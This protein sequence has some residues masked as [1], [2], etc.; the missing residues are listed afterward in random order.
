A[1]AG[2]GSARERLDQFFAL[3]MRPDTGLFGSGYAT[4]DVGSAGSMAIDGM[5]ITCWMSMGLIVGLVCIGALF[6]AIGN[7]IAGAWSCEGGNGETNVVIGA[8]ACSAIVQMPLANIISAE[9]G[10]LFWTFV[11]LVPAVSRPAR[12]RPR[13]GQVP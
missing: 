11:V 7:A 6:L 3:W 1:G 2:D 4:V 5:F 10:F 8:L 13:T 12:H 9:L